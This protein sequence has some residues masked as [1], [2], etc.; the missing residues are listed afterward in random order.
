MNTC[1]R[2]GVTASRSMPLAS[3]TI[4]ARADVSVP[5]AET[6]YPGTRG[7]EKGT[8]LGARRRDGENSCES[9]RDKNP[10]KPCV[11]PPAGGVISGGSGNSTGGGAGVNGGGC[12]AG[13]FL[14]AT[15]GGGF[16]VFAG[17]CDAPY[18]GTCALT[19]VETSVA[20]SAMRTWRLQSPGC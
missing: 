6:M 11:S 20:G 15:G 2:A 7:I 3:T 19:V 4:G 17:T 12:G 14:G 10:G 18:R 13:T 5:S 8:V 16:T 9:P 1:A